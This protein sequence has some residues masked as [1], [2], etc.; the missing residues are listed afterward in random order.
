M[1]NPDT[2]FIGFVAVV[3]VHELCVVE[4]ICLSP[5]STGLVVLI[6]LAL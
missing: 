3:R 1:P 5:D 2:T 4:E 6:T